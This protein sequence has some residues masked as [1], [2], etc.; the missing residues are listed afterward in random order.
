MKKSLIGTIWAILSVQ[1]RSQALV[2]LLAIFIGMLL[3]LLSIGVVFPLFSAIFEPEFIN[4]VEK[5]LGPGFAALDVVFT[6]MLG[7]SH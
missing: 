4:T 5:Y 3:E 7:Y 1:E 6:E 2:L